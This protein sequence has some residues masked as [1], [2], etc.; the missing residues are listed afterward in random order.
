[1]LVVDSPP[2]RVLSCKGGGADPTPA[3]VGW[4]TQRTPSAAAL[5]SVSKPLCPYCRNQLQL[6]TVQ[7]REDF[8]LDCWTC[9]QGHGM[10]LTLAESHDQLQEDELSRLWEL[11]RSGAPGPLPGLLGGPPMVRFVLPFDEDEVLEGEEG[12]TDDIGV[13]ELDVDLDNQFIWFDLGELEQ[14]PADLEDPEP[15]PQQQEALRQITQQFSV[16]IGEALEARDDREFSERI[17]QH[18]AR[19]PGMLRAFERIGRATTSY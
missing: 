7:L 15:T 9:S 19:R 8:P 2:P 13:V 18:V 3:T 16:G 4:V 14:L 11:A 17:Y 1:M 5:A 6:G 10:A 12:D